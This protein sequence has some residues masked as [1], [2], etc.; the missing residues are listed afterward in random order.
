MN[1]D[2]WDVAGMLLEHPNWAWQAGMRMCTRDD[3]VLGYYDGSLPEGA[4][5][6]L[7][8]FATGGA[9]LGVLD[10]LGILVDVA[11][12]AE[13]WIVA[14]ETPEGLKGWAADTLPEAAAWALLQNWEPDEESA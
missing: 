12:E 5:P 7:S 2:Q 3:E 13:E 9:L 14:V 10:G 11:R 4:W 6:D 8:A 1:A